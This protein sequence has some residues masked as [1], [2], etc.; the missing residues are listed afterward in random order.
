MAPAKQVSCHAS[1]LSSPFPH[2]SH[3]LINQLLT[4]LPHH[5]DPSR[6]GSRRSRREEEGARGYQS[7][8]PRCVKEGA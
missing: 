6:E 4:L 7:Q 3:H 1:F 2:L 5:T 8:A